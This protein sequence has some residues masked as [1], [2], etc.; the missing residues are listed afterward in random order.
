MNKKQ[1]QNWIKNDKF[2]DKEFK[3]NITEV[4]VKKAAKDKRVF[5]PETP[6]TKNDTFLINKTFCKWKKNYIESKFTDNEFNMCPYI[7][8][9][10]EFVWIFDTRINNKS[11]MK[12]FD[13]WRRESSKSDYPKTSEYETRE[14]EING[15]P[16]FE[17]GAWYDRDEILKRILKQKTAS[18]VSF[19]K[20]RMISISKIASHLERRLE[21]YNLKDEFQEI[22][23]QITESLERMGVTYYTCSGN[24]SEKY[25]WYEDFAM[26]PFIALDTTKFKQSLPWPAIPVNILLDIP[27]NDYESILRF[28]HQ[29]SLLRSIKDLY[30]PSWAKK[31]KNWDIREGEWVKVDI[32]YTKALVI[33]QLINLAHKTQLLTGVK[34][35]PIELNSQNTQSKY[36]DFLL[37]NWEDQEGYIEKQQIME[38][39]FERRFGDW[40][41]YMLN[42]IKSKV[43]IPVSETEP[44][45]N[46]SFKFSYFSPEIDD[47]LSNPGRMQ[48]DFKASHLLL[49]ITY[50]LFYFPKDNVIKVATEKGINFILTTISAFKVDFIKKIIE[51]GL[52][53]QYTPECHYKKFSFF[54]KT[55][56]VITSPSGTAINDIITESKRRNPG[57]KIILYPVKVHGE[58]ATWEIAHAIEFFN[59]KK[60]ADRLIVSQDGES[61]KDLKA[62][63]EKPVLLAMEISQI[64]VI[65]AVGSKTNITLCDKVADVNAFTPARAAKIAVTDM[66]NE[67]ASLLHKGANNLQTQ[68]LKKSQYLDEL[69]QT[70]TNIMNDFLKKKDNDFVILTAELNALSPL[71]IMSK[72]YTITRKDS[73]S[74]VVST[75]NVSVGDT[76]TTIVT[77]GSITSVISEVNQKG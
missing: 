47:I 8:D 10:G 55:I 2:C 28:L 23:R 72:G 49:K 52:N 29:A 3:K 51:Y 13:N 45:K 60:M 35:C 17:G 76:I 39:L 48:K 16:D 63:N 59:K 67:I 36:Y 27:E 58:E 53:F 74:L 70:M 12:N 62:F 7:I 68:I 43:R 22:W 1:L 9:E 65:S 71:S 15:T 38:R 34:E 19:V 11:V 54:S 42:V 5:I 69:V 56:G 44:L 61:I 66:Y 41:S 30:A 77:D 50:P 21:D 75:K 73:S 24:D 4:E 6:S 37:L 26:I 33:D 20:E 32:N 57:V 40:G 14:Y 31:P 64:P 18:P 25:L 46:S